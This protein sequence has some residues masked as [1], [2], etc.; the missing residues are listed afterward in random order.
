MDIVLLS[1]LM[2]SVMFNCNVSFILDIILVSF[3]VHLMFSK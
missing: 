1:I 3:N 2:L